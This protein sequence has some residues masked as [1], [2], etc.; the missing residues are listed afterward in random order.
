MAR[1]LRG[2]HRALQRLHT[3]FFLQ[4]FRSLP[5][6]RGKRPAAAKASPSFALAPALLAS[7]R[8]P[9][10]TATL[11]TSAPLPARIFQSIVPG[12]H[13]ADR[14]LRPVAISRQQASPSPAVPAIPL[15]KFAPSII[16]HYCRHEARRKVLSNAV[17][18]GVLLLEK[19]CKR[20]GINLAG[21]RCHHRG[22]FVLVP[23]QKVVCVIK[24]LTGLSLFKGDL[25]L[26]DH[27]HRRGPRRLGF[28]Q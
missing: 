12:R 28:K 25:A 9:P 11:P 19:S 3:C 6:L 15:A 23:K 20:T 2:T 4:A 5:H 17:Q 16:L 18:R 22:D 26:H 8:A 10:N 24:N 7:L 21:A 27:H 14:L 13:R 1:G